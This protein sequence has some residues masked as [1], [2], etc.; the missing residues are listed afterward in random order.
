MHP[1]AFNEAVKIWERLI[2]EVTDEEIKMEIDIRKKLFPG[3]RILL[4]HIQSQEFRI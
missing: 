2:R 1:T 3:R 4:L